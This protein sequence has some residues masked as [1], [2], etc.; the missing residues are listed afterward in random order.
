MDYVTFHSD[1][2]GDVRVVIVGKGVYFV[3]NDVAKVLK[4]KNM[5]R[6]IACTEFKVINVC[7][8]GKNLDAIGMFDISSMFWYGEVDYSY[9]GDFVRWLSNEVLPFMRVKAKGVP[10]TSLIDEV[11]FL[12]FELI[13]MSDQMREQIV[14]DKKLMTLTTGLSE[15]KDKQN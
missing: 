12:A 9:A 7:I 3:A 13:N 5:E 14:L 1:R 10:I 2:F 6:H 15:A 11:K 8:E 4:Y